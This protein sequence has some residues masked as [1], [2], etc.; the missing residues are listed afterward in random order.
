MLRHLGLFQIA[1]DI[2]D[3]TSTAE[4]LGKTPGKDEKEHKTTYVSL[5]GVERA[6]QLAEQAA[7]QAQQALV[8]FGKKTEFLS[9]TA[10]KAVKRRK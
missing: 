9:I 2:L 4:E 6:Q 8:R 3:V 5:Y 7:E 10:Q 1:D